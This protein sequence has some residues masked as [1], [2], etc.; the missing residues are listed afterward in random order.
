MAHR[1]ECVLTL[2]I[3]LLEKM[4]SNLLRP[5]TQY[6]VDDV[7]NNSPSTNISLKSFNRPNKTLLSRAASVL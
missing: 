4:L 6:K 7:Q 5:T 1:V 3:S 2:S